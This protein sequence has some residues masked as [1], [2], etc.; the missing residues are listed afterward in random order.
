MPDWGVAGL[1][2]VVVGGGGGCNL[3]GLT[4][5]VEPS[6]KLADNVFMVGGHLVKLLVRLF[7]APVQKGL[8]TR[9]LSEAQLCEA[10]GVC[11]IL[12]IPTVTTQ[13]GHQ[14]ADAVFLYIKGG[15]GDVG[16]HLHD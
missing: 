2:V 7:L 15:R 1:V 12:R 4:F 10:L 5:L 9:T 13:R 14:V 6:A 16:A 8:N 3:H 11:G